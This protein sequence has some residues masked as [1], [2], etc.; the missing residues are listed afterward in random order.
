[1][2][3]PHDDVGLAVLTNADSS[4]DTNVLI[5]HRVLRA[6]FGLSEDADPGVAPASQNAPSTGAQAGAGGE[7][8]SGNRDPPVDVDFTGSYAAAGY[9]PGFVLCNTSSTSAYCLETL[10][11][12]KSALGDDGLNAT[13]FFG[14]WPRLWSTHIG[15]AH[16]GGTSF[17]LQTL[18]VFPQGYGKNGSAF[19]FPEWTAEEGGPVMNCVVEEGTVRGCGLFGTVEQKT[20]REKKGGSIEE[21]ADVWFER[22]A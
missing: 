3:A 13:D 9:G 12:F 18:N 17:S 2:F 5:A 11:V 8:A 16:Q 7:E 4:D 10:A 14:A 6:A 1:M 20:I 22:F 21:T 19:I 15:F